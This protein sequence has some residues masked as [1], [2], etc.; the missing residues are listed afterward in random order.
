MT[1]TLIPGRG[2]PLAT[3]GARDA[4][5]SALNFRIEVMRRDALSISTVKAWSSSAVRLDSS[6]DRPRTRVAKSCV[7]LM[8]RS[9]VLSASATVTLLAAF[10]SPRFSSYVDWAKRSPA[11]KRGF[12]ET[13]ES[14]GPL[15][16]LILLARLLLAAATLLSALSELLV[17][18][19]GFCCWPPCWP[20]PILLTHI[21]PFLWC[22]STINNA[23]T[24]GP[25]PRVIHSLK[26]PFAGT[27]ECRCHG[28]HDLEPH[29]II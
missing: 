4:H 16:I 1:Q 29:H 6:R 26:F 18:W 23:G 17:C 13:G 8:A 12:K 22:R 7:L 15:P 3:A 10:L 24:S 9:A 2:Q 14:C 19:P 27:P 5:L 25:V 28:Q 20:P 21:V 11:G